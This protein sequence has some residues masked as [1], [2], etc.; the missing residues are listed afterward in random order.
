[1]T[2]KEAL[3]NLFTD[4]AR[5]TASADIYTTVCIIQYRRQPAERKKDYERNNA[6]EE[7]AGNGLK[8]ILPGAPIRIREICRR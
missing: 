1:M 4:T 6:I 2:N 7:N 3:K 5:A 8:G